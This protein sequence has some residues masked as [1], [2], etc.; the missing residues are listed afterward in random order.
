MRGSL[1]LTG[2]FCSFLLAGCLAHMT[3]PG[4]DPEEAAPPV[5]SLAEDPLVPSEQSVFAE[6][7]DSLGN[8]ATEMTLS[9]D[10]LA[11]T[12]ALEALPV[13]DETLAEDRLLQGQAQV[14]SET[15]DNAL[16]PEEPEF[17]F[18]VVENEQV[19]AFLDYFTGSGKRT[20]A[21]WLERSGRYL[22][23]MRDIFAEAGLPRDLAYLAM[24]E[25]GFNDKAYSWAH[26]V[27]P[28]QFIASTGHRYGLDNDWWHDE[29]RD[30]EMATRAAAAF[31]SDLYEEFDGDWYLAVAAYNA[32]PGKIRN[33]IRRYKSRDFWDICRGNYLKSETKNYL[34]KLLAALLIAKQPAKYGF[35]ELEYHAPLVY[36]TATLPSSTDIE[37][38]ARLSGS[39]YETIKTLNPA[40]KRWCTPPAESDYQVRLPVGSRE[41]FLT[42][43][44]ILPE[45][46]RANYVRHKV[47]SGDTLLALSK[48]YGVRVQDIRNL[49][50]IRNARALQI[51]TNLI[52]PLN[53][54]ASDTTPLAEL[55]DDYK[56]SRRTYYRVRSGD[57]LWEISRKF[58]VTEKQ[59]RVWNR[60]GWSNV[61]RPGQRLI[62][63]AKGAPSRT[64]TIHAAGPKQKVIYQ[65]RPG[66]TLWAIGREFSV[67]MAE[68]RHWNNLA[69]NHILQPGERL[70]LHVSSNRG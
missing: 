19:R 2:L 61:I 31:L 13:G 50:R 62:V 70:T 18:P 7:P 11:Q 30:P 33:A 69:E 10:L 44:T 21:L 8:S 5:A 29:R 56:R 1:F 28:W 27:G 3:A 68:I 6:S 49:N 9:Q 23:M 63:S 67:G 37:V 48:R 22:P 52:V 36:E 26:A 34:P 17:D 25:S 15:S 64:A 46:Q 45:Q 12:A 4:A 58:N 41:V 35:A 51:G 65:V 59:L 42:E 53:P 47:K 24:V 14:P 39:D 40:L 66:D 43:Y 57:S 60:L 54:D 32:G 16:V 38:I 20:F 55:K